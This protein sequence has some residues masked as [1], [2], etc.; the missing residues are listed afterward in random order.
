MPPRSSKR[1]ADVASSKADKAAK[2]AKTNEGW[3]GAGDDLKIKGGGTASQLLVY[4][5]PECVKSD[6]IVAFDIDWTIIKPKSGKKFP[7]GASDWMF[8]YP[9]VVPK[10]KE[11]HADG[12]KVVFVTNQAGVEKGK[13]TVQ[14]LTTKFTAMREAIGFPI[15]TLACTGENHFRKPSIQLWE[16]LIE[17]CNDG[18]QPDLSKCMFVGDAAGRAKNWAPNKP[19]DFNCSD[20]MFAE[21][22]GV[23]FQTPEEFFLKQG[24]VPF[25]YGSIDP[26]SLVKDEGPMDTA[27][28]DCSDQEMVVMVGC[29]ASG[30]SSISKDY[31]ETERQYSRVNRDEHGTKCAKMAAA[32]LAE[33]KSVVI[34]NT[35]P[36][37]TKRA[38]WL[39][40]AKKHKVPARCVHM[41]TP[42]PVAQHLN[43]FRQ[44]ITKG[45]HRRVPDVGYNMYFKHFEEPSVSEG[46]TH[47]HKMPFKPHF[48]DA[49]ARQLFLHWTC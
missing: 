17:E 23:K 28:L 31:Y 37:S 33:G 7:Q 16:Y 30:K 43:Q 46:F 21:N 8:L 20:R 40:L 29:A 26:K 44:N 24:S 4:D 32:F 15:T 14:E 9:E 49:R 22:I 41:T 10:L 34:D 18:I 13:S 5:T 25:A 6:R 35:N 42:R 47:V 27:E 19:K 12:F 1:A 36:S 11:L 38:E 2:K 3:Y 48:K 39:A 45:K